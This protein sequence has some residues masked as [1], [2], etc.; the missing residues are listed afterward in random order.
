M[1]KE[2]ILSQYFPATSEL[3]GEAFFKAMD[4]YAKQV[5]IGFGDWLQFNYQ[6]HATTGYYYD[7]HKKGDTG[8]EEIFS[9][10]ELYELYTKSKPLTHAKHIQR[11]PGHKHY[12]INTYCLFTDRC[13]RVQLSTKKQQAYLWR[14]RVNHQNK[15]LR[16]CNL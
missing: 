6:P 3:F 13:R 10:E 12:E 5:A 16:I 15:R 8:E 2:E 4:E 14:W 9:T 1:S 7:H 11:P